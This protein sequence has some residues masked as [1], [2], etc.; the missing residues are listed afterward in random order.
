MS[1]M[2]TTPVSRP[3]K[4][5]QLQKTYSSNNASLD[6]RSHLILQWVDKWVAEQG[7]P[8]APYSAIIRRALAMYVTHL[9]GLPPSDAPQAIQGLKLACGGTSTSREDREAAEARLEAAPSP[10][11]PLEVILKGQ[12]RVNADSALM[13]RLAALNHIPPSK[14]KSNE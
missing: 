4:T 9:E 5:L 14:A 11:P 1:R 3:R 10:L 6:Y 2:K 7:S 12:H 13:A 8:R